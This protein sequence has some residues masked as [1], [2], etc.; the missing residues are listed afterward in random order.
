[1]P[2]SK[3]QKLDEYYQNRNHVVGSEAWLTDEEL[4]TKTRIEEL[5]EP[6]H[7]H[8]SA[9]SK[10]ARKHKLDELMGKPVR[11]YGNIRG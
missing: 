9:A 11:T 5:E 10:A 6:N 1:M 3:S 2:K 7:P 8:N 4:A